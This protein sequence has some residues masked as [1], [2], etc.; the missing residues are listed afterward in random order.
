MPFGN[1]VTEKDIRNWL[2]RNGGEGRTAKIVDLE[3]FA[4]ERP[5]WKQVFRFRVK[6][7][8]SASEDVDHDSGDLEN[9][10]ND[11]AFGIVLDDERIRNVSE[12]TKIWTFKDPVEWQSRLDEIAQG[13][14]TCKTGQNGNSIWIVLLFALA[15]V[16]AVAVASIFGK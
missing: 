3:L 5:G 8:L 10:R 9:P 14:L 13:M 16:L 11:W 6:A 2:T 15:A 7:E 1:R 12:R 4:I